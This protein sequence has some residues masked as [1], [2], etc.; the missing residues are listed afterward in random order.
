MNL[1]DRHVVLFDFDG[2]LAD[3]MA[4]IV[5]V[6]SE[7]L[8]NW[9]MAPEELGDVSRLVGPPFPQAF[10]EVYGLSWEDALDV[11]ERYRLV[12]TKKGVEAWPV[13]PGVAQLLESLHAR[14]RRLGVVSS[15]RVDLV[16]RGVMDNALGDLFDVC[17][18]RTGDEGSKASRIVEA[19][20]QLG[21]DIDELI[22]SQPFVFASG[23]TAEAETIVMRFLQEINDRNTIRGGATIGPMVGADLPMPGCDIGAPML[24]MHS[25]RETMAADD[26]E[27]LYQ[28]I[29]A[30]FF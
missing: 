20:R 1:S 26:Y 21:V 17:L 14:G 11:T 28:L 22:L 16:K 9:G 3:T 15:K 2:T 25:A 24:A 30:Y 4:T 23:Q 18:G 19:V 7:V 6:A 5:E 29:S 12:Y 10:C 13:F 8:V 27:S